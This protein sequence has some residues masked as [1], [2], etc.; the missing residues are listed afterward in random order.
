MRLLKRPSCGAEQ[1]GLR[2][3]L[4]WRDMRWRLKWNLQ[5]SPLTSRLVLQ[6]LSLFCMLCIPP[7]YSDASKPDPAE[8]ETNPPRLGLLFLEPG[9][10]L[11]FTVKL[12]NQVVGRWLPRQHHIMCA[13]CV[14]PHRLWS[15]DNLGGGSS[16]NGDQTRRRRAH[17]VNAGHTGQRPK[18]IRWLL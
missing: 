10:A 3:L 6:R 2:Q 16:L 15:V 8:T 13:E 12:T 9:G 17:C 14:A 11:A 1:D 7:P 4:E 18:H 5:L